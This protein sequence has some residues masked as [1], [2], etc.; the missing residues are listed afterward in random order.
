MLNP[1]TRLSKKTTRHNIQPKTQHMSR[2]IIETF[3][4]HMTLVRYGNMGKFFYPGKIITNN[5]TRVTLLV[6]MLPG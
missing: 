1:I 2:D 5:F 6:I 3:I 4:Q